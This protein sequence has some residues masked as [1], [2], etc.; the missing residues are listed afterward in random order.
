M[1]DRDNQI[2]E[3]RPTDEVLPG[4]EA[5][6]I[7]NAIRSQTESERERFFK[8]D[9]PLDR[10]VIPQTFSIDTKGSFEFAMDFGRGVIKGHTKDAPLN[11]PHYSK[12]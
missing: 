12:P 10:D 9:T 2:C 1:A 11:R 8:C 4:L 5:G 3:N 6:P 7:V